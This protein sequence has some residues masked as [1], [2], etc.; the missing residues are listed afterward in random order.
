MNVK[1]NILNRLQYLIDEIPEKIANLSA[2]KLAEKNNP[3]KWSKKEILGHLC[4]SAFNNHCR[5]I[6]AQ[7]A[8]EPVK[9][10]PYE[11]NEWVTLN[12]YQ[13]MNMS[14][15]INLWVLLNK[16][17]LL[18]VENMPEE[19]LAVQCDLGGAAFRE[20]ENI[21]PLLWLIEDYVIHMEYHLKQIINED[22]L[23]NAYGRKE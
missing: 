9:I 5:F 12:A 20:G 21:K 18:V 15:I 11:Q 2:D 13:K 3:E 6:T 19:K 17:I 10:S 1:A 14:D 22:W 8:K 4:D 7:S 23:R 16:Q